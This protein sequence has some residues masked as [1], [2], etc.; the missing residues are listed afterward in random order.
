[1]NVITRKNEIQEVKLLTIHDRIK[2]ACDFASIDVSD[3]NPIELSSKVSSNIKDMI[4]TSELDTI[5]AGICMNLST[6]HPSYKKLGSTI[7]ISN[8]QKNCP[9]TFEACIDYLYNGL[10]RE[11]GERWELIDPETYA[12]A[13][14]YSKELQEMIVTD[15]DFLIDFF[16]FKTLERAYL[17]KDIVKKKPIETP[18]YMWMRVSIGIHKDNLSDIKKTYDLLST[19]KFTHATPTLFNSGTVGNNMISCFLLGVDDS[20]EGMYKAISDCAKISKFSGGIGI[21]I[22][23]LRPTGSIVKTT[24]GVSGGIRKYLKVLN[25]TARHVDQGGRRPGSIAVYLSTHHPD[26]FDFLDAGRN[27]GAEND[28][29]R[30]LFYALW[31]SD[32]FME[33]VT[34]MSDWYLINPVVSRDLPDLYGEAFTERYYELVEKYRHTKNITKI[35]ALD[36]WNHILTLQKETGMPYITYKCHVNRKSP[37]KNV[38]TIRS[39]NLCSEITLYSDTKEYACCNLVSLRLHSF[40]KKPTVKTV[41]IYGKKDCVYCKL[42]KAYLHTL[43]L[44]YKYIPLDDELICSMFYEKYNVSSVPQIFID[45]E[46][47]GGFEN[48][49]NKVKYYFDYEELR[50]VTRTAVENLNKIIDSNRYPVPETKLS[51]LRHRP[52]GIGVQG[53]ANVFEKLWLGY[54]SEAA[55]QLNKEIFEHIYFYA[56]ERSMELSKVNGPYSTFEGSPASKRILQFDMWDVKPVTDLKWDELKDEIV[57]H[58][59]YN[60]NFLALMPTSSTAQILGSNESFE[61]FTSNMYSRSTDAGEFTVVRDTLIDILNDLD[62]WDETMKSRIMYNRGKIGSI[63]GIPDIIKEMYLTSWEMSN[64][65]MIDMAAARGAYICQTQSL[66]MFVENPSLELLSK[67]HTYSWKS[68]LKTGSYYIR[69]KSAAN[70]QSFTIDPV[71]EEIFSNETDTTRECLSCGS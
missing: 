33:A 32:A 7:A 36:L 48:L 37:Q 42:S 1:M 56:L 69:T 39:S 40:L 60:S 49:R 71:M 67:I 59:L 15:R 45:D 61:A 53:L 65:K 12:I 34:T 41:R 20:I 24:N 18:Q 28:K 2:K 52:I 70:A 54:Q 17:I 14:K 62:L 31:V 8:H 57:T 11:D 68:K 27:Q 26:I 51:N 43:D 38:G 9:S 22:S 13:K 30:D 29:S 64:K 63:S 16:G 50:T 3:I 58:G 55:Q 35:N 19:K 25:D 5:T 10:Q 21:H 47:I 66:N 4:T 23:N 46:L 6:R 44:D